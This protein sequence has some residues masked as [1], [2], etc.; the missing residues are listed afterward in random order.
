LIQRTKAWVRQRAENLYLFASIILVIL[1][2]IT[3]PISRLVFGLTLIWLTFVM[4]RVT[5]R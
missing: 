1:M 3:G 4:L 2:I 5:K